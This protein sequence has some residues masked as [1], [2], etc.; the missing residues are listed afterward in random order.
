MLIAPHQIILK[1]V[2]PASLAGSH[3]VDQNMGG[4]L[5]NAA[6]VNIAAVHDPRTDEYDDVVVLKMNFQK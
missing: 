6:A 5:V 1:I 2:N 3:S 4:R